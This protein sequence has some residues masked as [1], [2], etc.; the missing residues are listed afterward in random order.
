V[1]SFQFYAFSHFS[2]NH[3]FLTYVRDDRVSFLPELQS[4]I[5]L[6]EL[7]SFIFFTRITWFHF[8]QNYR[9]SFFYQN[10]RVLQDMYFE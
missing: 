4:F 9:V 5:F 10:Y 7:Q 2:L 1:Q 3:S 8:Y 6:P